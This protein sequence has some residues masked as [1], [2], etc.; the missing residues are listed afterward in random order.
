MMRRMRRMIRMS[1]RGRVS[2][3]RWKIKWPGAHHVSLC[4]CLSMASSVCTI[5]HLSY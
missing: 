3:S 5:N 4:L 2:R 1:R